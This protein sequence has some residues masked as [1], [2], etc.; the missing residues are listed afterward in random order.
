MYDSSRRGCVALDSECY[1]GLR[2]PLWFVSAAQWWMPWPHS[3]WSISIDSIARNW[4]TRKS[5]NA[6]RFCPVEPALYTEIS[7]TW[8]SSGHFPAEVGAASHLVPTPEFPFFLPSEICCPEPWKHFCLKTGDPRAKHGSCCNKQIHRPLFFTVLNSVAYFRVFLAKSSDWTMSLAVEQRASMYCTSPGLCL[9]S[10]SGTWIQHSNLKGGR[11]RHTLNVCV[12]AHVCVCTCVCVP[13]GWGNMPP[14]M[15]V[16]KE[17]DPH[18]GEPHWRF[19]SLQS[20]GQQ[21]P[22]D[23]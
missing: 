4:L 1:S 23:P 10:F 17:P 9:H 20:S 16:G 14:L 6:R 2:L 19:L 3:L 8:E 18:A 21:F 13:W 11:Y 7:G 15:N 22:E 5:L 12:C